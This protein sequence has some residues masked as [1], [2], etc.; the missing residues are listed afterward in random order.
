MTHR[1]GATSIDRSMTKIDH[2]P[3][4]IRVDEL[5][6]HLDEPAWRVVDC[7]FDLMAPASGQAEYAQGHIPGAQYANLDEDL[8]GPLSTSTGRHPLPSTT[9]FAHTLGEWGIDNESQVVV[10]DHCSGAIAAR[11][12]WMLKWLGHEQVAVLNGGY[13][14]WQEAGYAVSASDE[15]VASVKFEPDS[16]CDVVITTDELV[17]ALKADNAPLI[18]DARDGARF[19]GRSEPID[20]VAGHIPGAVNHPFSESMEANGRWKS[21]DQLRDR[22]ALILGG[23]ADQS[24]VSMCGSG[25]TACHLAL[26]AGVAGLPQPRLYIGSWSEWIRNPD[27]PVARAADLR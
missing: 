27:R 7:R 14:A 2:F 24:W 4:L 11:L 10:Y 17:Q 23:D 15:S 19:A 5:Q 25:V 20:A 9:D 12:W 16:V 21:P 3:Y 1:R 13:A 22:W 6:G 18:V 8:A 26:S